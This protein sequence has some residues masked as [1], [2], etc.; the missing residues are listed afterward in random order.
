MTKTLLFYD[1]SVNGN[2]EY[3][4][5]KTKNITKKMIL[6]NNYVYFINDDAI[7]EFN[8]CN[9]NYMKIKDRLTFDIYKVYYYI[10]KIDID[11]YKILVIEINNDEFIKIYNNNNN[12]DINNFLITSFNNNNLYENDVSISQMEEKSNIVMEQY[13]NMTQNNI[14]NE[15]EINF[16]NYEL[17]SYQKKTI[18]WMC[19]IENTKWIY[20][21]CK[22]WEIILND[23]NYKY[24]YKLK[25]LNTIKHLEFKGGALI[26]EMGLGKTV[27]AISLCIINQPINKEYK[28]DKYN[29]L[30][31][32][33]TLII[34]PSHL[35]KQWEDEINKFIKK[36]K[37][38][39][40]ILIFTKLHYKKYTYKDLLDADFV[41]TTF[42]F[43][44][45]SCFTEIFDDKH[46]YFTSS[47]YNHNTTA[48]FLHNLGINIK[49]NTDV[50]D[51]DKIKSVNFL[52]IHW[53]RK[54]SDEFHE[55]FTNN[56]LS[57]VS[58][59]FKV[60]ESDYSWILTGTP[61][62]ERSNKTSLLK[63]MDFIVSYKNEIDDEI[64][65]NENIFD[66]LHNNFFRRNTKKSIQDEYTL[67]PLKETVFMLNFS[68]TESYIYNSY[69]KNEYNTS[70]LFLRQFC[71]YP[72]L[73]EEIKQLC[74]LDDNEDTLK[75]IENKM[76]NFYFNDMNIALL[77][78]QKIKNKIIKIEY[79]IKKMTYNLQKKLLKDK[80]FDVTI[81]IE[82]IKLIEVIK[83][84]N[85]FLHSNNF[86]NNIDIDNDD[87]IDDINIDNNN[88]N[89]NDKNKNKK[90]TFI[91]SDNTQDDI[92]KILKN[93]KMTD[94]INI[95]YEK[96]NTVNLQYMENLKIYEGKKGTYEYYANVIN[97]LKNIKDNK[98]SENNDETCCICLCT[99]ENTTLGLTQ[100]GHI[101]C[102]SCI[103]TSIN[104][105]N[106]CPLCKTVVNK[107]EIYCIRQNVKLINPETVLQINNKNELVNKIGTK[108]T[109]LLLYLQNIKKHCIIFSHWDDC[110]IK[111]GNL[112]NEYGIKNL[113]CK[114]NVWQKT[115]IIKKFN[116]SDDIKIIMISSEHSSAGTNLTKAKIVIFLEPVYGS[117]EFRTSIEAQAIARSHRIGQTEQV[118]IVRFIIKNTI[119]EEIYNSNKLNSEKIDTVEINENNIILKKENIETINTNINNKKYKTPKKKNN[120]IN[121]AIIT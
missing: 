65:Y 97:T 50:K 109:N 78:T 57:H 31:S 70:T 115:N 88:N 46:M 16:L 110:L 45:N 95:E 73:S 14:Y 77:K 93:I 64:L 58:N 112:L 118:E 19:D 82:P 4:N 37:N 25:Q 99:L 119:E 101:Y 114:G 68:D 27:Q 63:M 120:N 121:N 18:K 91:V 40:T 96:L 60:L 94:T 81:E 102:F 10:F 9:S 3:N 74:I 89:I 11:N 26:D 55:I 43:L 69:K 47:M 107:K 13:K 92:K 67:I 83:L 23:T 2:N 113:F 17:Y 52:N 71:C 15:I 90:N 104:I 84:D 62:F 106:I 30:F 39:K 86:L 33:A 36:D 61:F 117:L 34:C 76:V 105:K 20:E 22:K 32:R 59:I 116:D 51:L 98:I 28:Q 1:K 12:S 24:N 79:K 48:N 56:R 75:N 5:E 100:C 8:K 87:I 49:N 66:K 6:D 85:S 53:H 111:V 29:K 35:G 108:L 54:I 41:I 44:E 42:N 21:Y 7:E 72:Q 103:E 80:G 38:I